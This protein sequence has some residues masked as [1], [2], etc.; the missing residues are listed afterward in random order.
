MRDSTAWG[1]GEARGG[2]GAPPWAD[3]SMS[4]LASSFHLDAGASVGVMGEVGERT[5][6]LPVKD[7]VEGEEWLWDETEGE[8][9]TVRRSDASALLANDPVGSGLT[10]PQV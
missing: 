2:A 6:G 5:V 4:T 8:A 1:P 7:G 10:A 3:A 9:W